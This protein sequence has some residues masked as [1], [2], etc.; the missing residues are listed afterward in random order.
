M[1]HVILLLM[2]KT[3]QFVTQLAQDAGEMLLDY[4]KQQDLKTSLKGDRSIVTEAD[5]AADRLISSAIQERF[6]D[7]LL[8]SEELSPEYPSGQGAPVIW[9][10]DPVDGTTNFSLG[11]HVWGILITRVVD[12]WPDLSVMHFPY[13]NEL[14][15]V[16]RGEGAD[17]NGLPLRVE[18]PDRNR[19]AAFFTCCSRTHRYYKIRI[20]YKPRILGSA[21]YSFCSVARNAALIGFEATP[22]IWDIA[23]GWLL[24]NEAQG[25]VET[26]DGSQ[27]FPLRPGI[28]YAKQ[29]YPTVMAATPELAAQAHRQIQPR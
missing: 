27:P 3:L 1:S 5:L 26:L 4:F 13:I 25:I 16:K 18:P 2:D 7:D 24:L 15:T 17:L 9:I 19:P 21:A 8:L 28:P 11:L 10:I 14:Y 12:G 23:G 20:P 6:P 29:S 22:K